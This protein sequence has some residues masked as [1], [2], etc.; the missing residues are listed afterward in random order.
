[1]KK[2]LEQNKYLND[3]KTITKSYISFLQGYSDTYRFS[4]NEIVEL[5]RYVLCLSLRL[6]TSKNF[7]NKKFENMVD[8]C[9]LCL[10]PQ[11][12]KFENRDDKFKQGLVQ[13]CIHC[14]VLSFVNA[15]EVTK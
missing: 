6:E 10:R 3:I 5:F 8:A 7:N 2:R 14:I 12:I 13:G 4:D 1:M 15:N 11:T 9:R